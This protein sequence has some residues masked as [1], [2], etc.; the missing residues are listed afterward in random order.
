[1]ASLIIVLIR[2]RDRLPVREGRRLRRR[3]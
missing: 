2:N 3:G 1:M